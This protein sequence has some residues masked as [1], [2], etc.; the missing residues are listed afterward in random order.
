MRI[1]APILLGLIAIGGF[2]GLTMF[3][4]KSSSSSDGTGLMAALLDQVVS[5]F[6][7]EPKK[8]V[9]NLAD[10]LPA[11]PDGWFAKPYQTADGEEIT[12]SSYRKSVV[13][14]D[15]TNTILTT[16]ESARTSSLGGA[17]TY[18]R[19]DQKVVL[20]LRMRSE[21]DMK[22]LQGSLM[23]AISGQLAAA[24][25]RDW[26]KDD[27]AQ[28][29]GVAFVESRRENKVI[30]TST[31]LP[32]N[33]RKF[34]AS[35]GGQLSIDLLTNASDA[36]VASIIQEIDIIGLNDALMEPDPG[37]T[38]ATGFVTRTPGRLDTEPPAPSP[39][40]MAYTILRDGTRVP[41]N[42]AR[43]L[44]RVAEFD[45][46]D[47]SDVID[48][49]GE[50]P[51]VSST[52]LAVMGPKPPEGMDRHTV[53]RAE[54]LARNPDRWSPQEFILLMAIIDGGVIYKEDAAAY[55]DYEDDMHEEIISLISRLPSD[56]SQTQA[57]AG[58]S[59]DDAGPTVRRG[60]DA[61]QTTSLGGDCSIELGVR[62]CVVSEGQTDG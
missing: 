12:D 32:V 52:A 55:A 9:V 59:D 54:N 60:V 53:S 39:A 10:F 48:Q 25:N 49:Y 45:I 11:S 62:R 15:T 29:Y 58:R 51:D 47:W 38:A 3:Q 4:A 46:M 17:M 61:K 5:D 30:S 33:Y 26:N 31:T 57:V 8:E 24:S 13:A 56:E 7:P 42:D 35:M 23:T 16:F 44:A 28:L 21:R 27:F 14:I 43:F 34:S 20:A 1:L 41:P 6:T 40:F 18:L 22:S 37:V 2:I 50:T 19:G 36:A